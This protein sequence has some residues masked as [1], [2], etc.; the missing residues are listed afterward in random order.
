[1]EETISLQKYLTSGVENIVK[2]AVHT[3]LT[4]KVQSILWPVLLSQ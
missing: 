1:M 4:N 3:S 2:N